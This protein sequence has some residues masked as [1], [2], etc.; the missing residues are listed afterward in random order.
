MHAIIRR[1]RSGRAWRF[2][3]VYGLGMVAAEILLIAGFGL[4]VPEDNARVAP[5]LFLLVPLP[6]ALFCGFRGLRRVLAVG[7]LAVAFTV[8]LS[9]TFGAATGLLAPLFV[10]P[11]AGLAAA[12][13]AGD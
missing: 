9:V 1:L 4:R 3:A 2:A 7:L 10:R 12:S 6:V 11:L 8:A 13:L 5:L